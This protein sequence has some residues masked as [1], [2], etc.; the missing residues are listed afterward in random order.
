M[1]F[2]G[3]HLEIVLLRISIISKKNNFEQKISFDR[4]YLQQINLLVIYELTWIC[5]DFK[6]PIN[7]IIR[8]V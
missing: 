4:S 1:G 3:F 8:M 5:L 2:D 6:G 7:K